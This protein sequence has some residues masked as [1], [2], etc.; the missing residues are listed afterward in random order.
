MKKEENKILYL[1]KIILFTMF[2]MLCLVTKSVYAEENTKNVGV[3]TGAMTNTGVIVGVV[4]AGVIG[5][6]IA[7]VR[8]KRK[9]NE[10]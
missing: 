6:A 3:P 8:K 7:M 10:K 9:R 4:M 2:C 5:I 1:M